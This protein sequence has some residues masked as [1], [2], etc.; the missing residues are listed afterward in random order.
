M[1]GIEKIYVYSIMYKIIK[2]IENTKKVYKKVT[3]KK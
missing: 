1:N 2:C 3:K